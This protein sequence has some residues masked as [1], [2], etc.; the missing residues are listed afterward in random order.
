[1][2]LYTIPAGQRLY[3]ICTDKYPSNAF[4]SG[5]G[6]AY[7]FSPLFDGEGNVIPSMYLGVTHTEAMAETLFRQEEGERRRFDIAKIEKKK[8]VH[9]DVEHDLVLLDLQSIG[10]I[11]GLL[12]QG[13]SAYP[14]LHR[15]AATLLALPQLSHIHGFIWDSYQRKA[16]GVGAMRVM[17]LYETRVNP[18]VLTERLSEYLL[19]PTGFNKLEDV[20]RALNCDIPESVKNLANEISRKSVR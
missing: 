8:L 5:N 6:G 2:K 9:L 18:P 4:N 15:V 11:A 14:K 20:S 3:R 1:M 10:K 16:S 7:R 19:H 12:E 13:K 17:V